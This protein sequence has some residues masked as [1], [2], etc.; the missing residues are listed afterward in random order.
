[1]AALADEIEV[2]ALGQRQDEAGLTS[3]A[4]EGAL[5]VGV[6]NALFLAGQVVGG[7]DLLDAVKGL[8]A[9]DGLVA[10]GVYCTTEGDVADVVGVVQD[11]AH[12]S[13]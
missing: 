9:D 11:A 3:G 2:G 7:E 1:M 13:D 5:E 8:A 4:V 6:V 12:L 10:A